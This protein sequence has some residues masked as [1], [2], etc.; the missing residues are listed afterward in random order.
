[1]PLKPN[2]VPVV[3]PIRGVRERRVGAVVAEA[4]LVDRR[5]ADR[6]RPAG[7]EA[8]IAAVLLAAP[9]RAVI[10]GRLED[11]AA[12]DVLLQEAVADEEAIALG[13]VVV[14]ADVELVRV[15]GLRPR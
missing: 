13:Q 6:A 11:R 10:D 1:M 14:A 3:P 8:L 5:R 15:L 7:A 12:E 9:L 4:Q 2:S